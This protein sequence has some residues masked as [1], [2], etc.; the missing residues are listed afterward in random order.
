MHTAT[1][2]TADNGQ[3]LLGRRKT[4]VL[5][6]T[7]TVGQCQLVDDDIVYLEYNEEQLRNPNARANKGAIPLCPF[8]LAS[9]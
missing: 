9:C 1:R 7:S 8:A 6:L 3:V 5:S 4:S 2:P